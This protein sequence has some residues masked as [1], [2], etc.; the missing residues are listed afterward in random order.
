M[1]TSR[2]A[3]VLRADRLNQARP[4]RPM[5][6]SVL[7]FVAVLSAAA[8]GSPNGATGADDVRDDDTIVSA[9]A[10]DASVEPVLVPAVDE[11]L[12]PIGGVLLVPLRLTEVPSAGDPAEVVPGPAPTAA[13]PTFPPIDARVPDTIEIGLPGGDS[14]TALVAVIAAR[15]PIVT[16]ARAASVLPAGWTDIRTRADVLAPSVARSASRTGPLV[17][18]A[19]LS[20]GPG[21]ADLPR[22]A[23]ITVEGIDVTVALRPW[24]V[25]YTGQ[26]LPDEGFPR[27]TRESAPDL[28]DPEDP[29]DYWRW[30]LLADEIGWRPP[31]PPG[32]ARSRML[33][34]HGAARWRMGLARIGARHPGVASAVRD[35]V[36]LRVDAIR[37]D[38]S[39]YA[40][41]PR[42]T[43]LTPRPGV[44]PIVQADAH[45]PP[46]R[47]AAWQTD[48]RE[49]DRVLG[50]MLDESRD[51]SRLAEPLLAWTESAEP[52]LVWKAA[53]GPTGRASVDVH[54][55]NR[56]VSPRRIRVAWE[57]TAQDRRE[58]SIPPR[59]VRRITMRRPAAR[60]ADRDA[61]LPATA[62][63]PTPR[64]G[65]PTAMVPPPT[66]EPAL[67]SSGPDALLIEDLNGR[68]W[69][70]VFE[71]PWIVAR[72][73]GVDL[74][75]R[76]AVTLADVAAG[77]QA[78]PF[79][80]IGASADL[81]LRR[82]AGRWEL[83]VECRR[84]PVR[85]AGE[86]DAELATAP[87]EVASVD[88]G[89]AEDRVRVAIGPF[90]GEMLIEIPETGPVVMLG[91]DGTRTTATAVIRRSW[92]DRWYAR[93]PLPAE[94]TRD[95]FLTVAAWRTVGA[96]PAA[97]TAPGPVPGWR[98]DPG[99][100]HVD[101]GGWDD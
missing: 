75:P 96:A 93:V 33:A 18:L 36:T 32:D 31:P 10:P 20:P 95:G 86:T 4:N 3:S 85:P 27:L 83:F 67:V 100:I 21:E 84:P 43:D 8:L 87:P 12:A 9:P 76:P 6:F 39:R 23:V 55:L 15:P 16:V 42:R 57:D 62:A 2:V 65:S 92:P 29:A 98:R 41:P 26:P 97:A 51:V 94:L 45:D 34:E 68:T 82:R 38:G 79:A 74:T 1:A 52:L 48:T 54:V 77:R 46:A 47:L 56:S 19:R 63:P 64:P 44:R 7:P 24:Q 71:G 101:L 35:A 89:A 37:S 49:L 53:S 40:E 25:P 81:R 13:P 90:A 72:P 5:R 91:P 50:W 60:D 78:D 17:A 80:A 28:P 22:D 88:G 14:I 30:V 11:L 59:S 99:R 61:S 58:L 73:P 69:R 70:V 66:V